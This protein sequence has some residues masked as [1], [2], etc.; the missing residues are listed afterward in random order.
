MRVPR[1]EHAARDKATSC[2]PGSSAK[3]ALLA[4]GMP[5]N[6][7]KLEFLMICLS[8]PGVS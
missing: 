4:E 2:L 7:R 8:N 3:E 5:K 1:V 6:E